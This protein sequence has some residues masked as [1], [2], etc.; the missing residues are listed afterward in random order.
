MLSFVSIKYRIENVR[1]RKYVI[2]RTF[3]W[4]STYLSNARVNIWWKRYRRETAKKFSWNQG[5]S[6]DQRKNVVNFENVYKQWNAVIIKQVIVNYRIELKRQQKKKR[7]ENYLSNMN[8]ILCYR[9]GHDQLTFTL[10]WG[11]FELKG[12]ESWVYHRKEHDW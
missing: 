8:L 12:R 7:K 6:W 1:E 3:W 4:M 10:E 11:G 2:F 9:T 5:Q